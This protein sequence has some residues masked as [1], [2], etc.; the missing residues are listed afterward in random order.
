MTNKLKINYT[1]SP[2]LEDIQ[3]LG[4]GIAAY[5]KKQKNLDPAESFGFFIHDEKNQLIGGCNGVMYY[6]CLYI[7]QLWLDESIRNHG[8]GTQLIQAAENLGK[9]RKCSFATVNTMD[10]E[11]RDFYK[12]CGY[13]E[14]YARSGYA[15]DSTIYF[16]RKN[17]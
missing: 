10:W 13:V 17:L 15:E 3:I 4:D 5:A 7:D 8:Y 14:E 12:K 1:Q 11:A 9:Q 2:S 16:L 6:G